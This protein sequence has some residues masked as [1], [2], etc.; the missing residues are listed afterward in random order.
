M[1]SFRLRVCQAEQ[2]HLRRA[3]QQSSGV[4][5]LNSKLPVGEKGSFGDAMRDAHD[6]RG[7]LQIG[8]HPLGHTVL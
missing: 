5:F 1:E 8:C 3:T 4:S 6:P 2:R 7:R